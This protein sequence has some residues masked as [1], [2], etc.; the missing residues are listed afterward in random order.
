MDAPVLLGTLASAYGKTNIKVKHEKLLTRK[1]KGY[2]V[3]KI[4]KRRYA[5]HTWDIVEIQMNVVHE[6]MGVKIWSGS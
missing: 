6:Q 5:S 3:F 2:S 4:T 1:L